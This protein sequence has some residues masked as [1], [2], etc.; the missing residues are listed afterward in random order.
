MTELNTGYTGQDGQ[1]VHPQL[2]NTCKT[3]GGTWYVPLLDSDGN[4][5]VALVASTAVV[6]K[7]RLVDANGTE[8]TDGTQSDLK[9]HRGKAALSSSG[10]KTGD[11]KI[12]AGSGEVYWLTVS[13]TA[14][15]ALELNDSANN[16][17][18]DQWG[19]DL[20]AGAYAHFIFD[21]PIEFSNG[22]YLDVSTATCKV[23]IGYK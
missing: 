6:G 11:A 12:K 22:I 14:A 17:G 8:V 15:L 9:T 19:L 1:I 2:G 10:V 5:A 21:P 23:T 16:T 13:D 7:V 4:R 18:V 20:P 3:G